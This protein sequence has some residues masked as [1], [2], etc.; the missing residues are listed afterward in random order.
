MILAVDLG[1]TKA[2]VVAADSKGHILGFGDDK[3]WVEEELERRM[4]KMVRIRF[5][6]ENALREAGLRAADIRRVSACC[7]G[8][9]W[10]FEFPIGARQL[11]E[12][13]GVRDVF[14]SNDCIGA[15][16]GGVEMIGR[17]CA[18]LCLGTGSNCAVYNREGE[19]YEYAYY[20]KD[21]H[22]GGE[23]IG[24]F[25]AEAVVDAYAGI[26]PRTALTQLLLDYT[27]FGSVEEFHMLRTTGRSEHEPP[28]R[29]AYK[30]YCPLLFQAIQMNDA[31]A[32][33]YIDS[34][35][36][37]LAKYVVVAARRLGIE[38]RSLP[39]VI[40]GGVCK[41]DSVIP[42][43]VAKHI[44]AEIPEAYCVNA[45]FEPVVGALLLEYDRAYPAGIP[46]DVMKALED[47]CVKYGLYREP[48][49]NAGSDDS[50]KKPA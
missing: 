13:L 42:E 50:I 25:I 41:G 2:H 40:S 5:A 29:P 9:D 43:L 1:G 47:S 35:C 12:V 23:A 21:E 33:R 20:L 45:R 48:G 18:V 36:A 37:A 44:R 34:F 17:D 26:A 46:A 7:S 8:A 6:A 10:P 3:E 15:L 11:R 16:R 28:A 14:Y 30:D 38:G 22:Q 32:T 39:V 31:V 49:R 4:R 19:S 24:R 27:G